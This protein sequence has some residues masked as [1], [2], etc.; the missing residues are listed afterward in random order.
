MKD[1]SYIT[2]S[3]PSFIEGMYQQFLNDA[4]SVD[5]DLKKFFEGFDFA[6]QNGSITS[7]A[8]SSASANPIATSNADWAIEIKV[9]RLILG[10]RNK[11]DITNLPPGVLTVGSK[12]VLIND[13][14]RV[15]IRQGFELDGQENT[16]NTPIVS[17]FD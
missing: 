7:V 1:F 6:M 3:H 13:G 2:N 16:A 4:S 15:A 14:E 17:S 10:Y 12:N 11:E 8:T 9:Y 5:P